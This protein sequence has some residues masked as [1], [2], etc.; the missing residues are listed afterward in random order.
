MPAG[1][2]AISERLRV[3][4]LL[5]VT[6]AV[7]AN[8]LLNGFAFDDNLY[9]LSDPRVTN[10]S[11]GGLFAATKY[12]NVFR[13]AT[14]GSFALDWA[15]AGSHAFFYH[16]VNVLLHAGVTLLLYFLLR[17]LLANV[18]RGALIAWAAALIFAVHPIHTEAVTAISGRAELLAV[19]FVLAAWLLHLEDRPTAALLCFVIAMLSKESAVVF[20]PLVVLTDYAQNRLKNISRYAWIG[21]VTLAYLAALRY[22]QGGHFGEKS[23]S[24]LDNPLA[25]FPAN[26][27]ILNALRIAWR[28][29]GL[30]VY[31]ATLSSDYSY[32]AITLYAKWRYGIVAL[33]ATLLVVGLWLWAMWT[34]R[35]MWALAGT[36]YLVG[37]SVTANIL[38]PTG[39]IM[40]E[41]LAY[42]PSAGFCLLL[43][44][45]WV[46]LEER[47][48][49][50]AWVALA[51]VIAALSGRTIARNRDW[52]NNDTLSAA[53]VKAAPG[54]AKMHANMAAQY[55]YRNDV[56]AAGREAK[57][58]L[59][60]YPDLADAMG[61]LALVEARNGNDQSAREL[62][63]KALKNTL[64]TNPNY[65]FMSINLAAV[66]MKLGD[67]NQALA[68]LNEEI[69]KSSGL[70]KAS[71]GLSRAWS[72]RAVIYY[73]QGQTEK[74]RSD[75]ET[76]VR[77][78]SQNA[79][80]QSLLGLLGQNGATVAQP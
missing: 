59:R 39:T 78:D 79:Q 1:E 58:A 50:I 6:L 34:K 14:F 76:A 5:G 2:F 47:S 27:R 42:L 46:R 24:F 64:P 45:L 30:L 74:A 20:A 25:H 19:G 41:R 33:A 10:P 21:A 63:E 17:K 70:S 44:L 73:Q 13:P 40:G 49:T 43:A 67:Y 8:A 12:A 9:I 65:D 52:R 69:E 56:E 55:Y 23:V 7:Y 61:C 80:A 38:V 60:I 32:N 68:V 37:F 28:Y 16:L 53:D 77:M 51:L 26:L 54:S 3:V 57:T 18:Q 22:A 72:N 15:I 11:L 36:L 35:T 48:R 66:L 29:V 62:L 31:P 75:A 71:P 4:L